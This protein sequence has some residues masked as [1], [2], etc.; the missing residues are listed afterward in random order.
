MKK[1]K[2]FFLILFILMMMFLSG[3]FNKIEEKFYIEQ[4]ETVSINIGD[5]L[6]YNNIT[7]ESNNDILVFKD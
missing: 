6:K 1:N 5:S 3:C 7:F 2:S 4:I